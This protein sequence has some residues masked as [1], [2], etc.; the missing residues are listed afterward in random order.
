MIDDGSSRS[1][2]GSSSFS[3]KND[4]PRPYLAKRKKACFRSS[5][6]KKT[7]IKIGKRR[8]LSRGDY[9]WID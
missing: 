3:G 4:G 8:K 7:G 9:L 5:G 1:G 2:V 6:K